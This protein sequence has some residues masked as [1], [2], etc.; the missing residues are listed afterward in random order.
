MQVFEGQKVV[1]SRS[2]S[3]YVMRKKQ[4]GRQLNKDKSC[5]VMS[6]VGSQMRR[7]NEKL[8]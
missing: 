5:K 1:M 2:D 3:K 6:S 7:E 4:G 8:L